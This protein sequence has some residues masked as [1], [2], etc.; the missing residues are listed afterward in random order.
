MV[1]AFKN[2]CEIEVYRYK[3]QLRIDRTRARRPLAVARAQRPGRRSSSHAAH[4]RHGPGGRR[5][6]QRPRAGRAFG[7]SFE[8]FLEGFSRIFEDFQGFSRAKGSS[9]WMFRAFWLGFKRRTSQEFALN[10]PA[11]DRA[12][13]EARERMRV[14]AVAGVVQ[15]DH[16]RRP[17]VQR[18]EMCLGALRHR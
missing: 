16:Q 8:A 15:A 6:L 9:F 10:M 14:R 3:N 7:A 11:F 13:D 12:F 5:G 4:E 1:C 2:R 18:E 17:M